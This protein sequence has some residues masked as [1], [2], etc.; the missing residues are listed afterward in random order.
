[1]VLSSFVTAVLAAATVTPAEVARFGADVVADFQ[2]GVDGLS[3]RYDREATLDR[4]LKGVPG[5]PDELEEFRKGFRKSVPGDELLDTVKTGGVVAFRR[6]VTLDGEPA[7]RFCMHTKQ[8]AFN[9]IE[10]K[11]AKN[12]KGEVKAVDD[13]DLKSGETRSQGSHRIFMAVQAANQPQSPETDVRDAKALL[14]LIQASNTGAWADVIAAYRKLSPVLQGDRLAA[15]RY[16]SAL[17]QTDDA[18]Y[19]AAVPKY[20]QTHSAD[21]STAVMAVRFHMEQKQW[22]EALRAIDAGEKRIGGD[23]GWAEEERGGVAYEQGDMAAAKLHCS[24]AVAREP[25]VRAPYDML[26]EIAVNEKNHGDTAKWLTAMERDLKLKLADISAVP[27]F[28]GFVASK[29][30]QVFVKT[31]PRTAH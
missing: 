9:L 13:W 31:H 5:A 25:L 19:R 4:A 10:I 28:A 16:L 26:L 11:L 12:A 30:G 1:M 14:A 15:T 7:A 2:R 3:A 29:E 24:Q 6:A 20:L 17:A 18:A 8:G 27:M 23:D 21:P 22:S